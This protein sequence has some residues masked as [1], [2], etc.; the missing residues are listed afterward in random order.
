MKNFC[1]GFECSCGE[2]IMIHFNAKNYTICPNCCKKHIGNIVSEVRASQN[3]NN[4]ISVE[5]KIGE[6]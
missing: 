6:E 5:I 3:D 2:L 4:V 1:T